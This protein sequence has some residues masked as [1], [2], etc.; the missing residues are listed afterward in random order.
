MDSVNRAN[1]RGGALDNFRKSL[2]A[3]KWYEW[4]LAAVMVAIALKAMLDAFIDPGSG[5]NPAWLTA[6]NFVSALAGVLCVFF[7]AKASVSNYLF[8]LVNTAAYIVYLWYWHIWGTFGLEVFLYLP[9]WV[10]GW[11]HWAR[12]LDEQ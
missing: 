6:V 2:K 3:L 1:A 5:K 10:V 8:G 9:M 7:C 12:L 4:L 11:V